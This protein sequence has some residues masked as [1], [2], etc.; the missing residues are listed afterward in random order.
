MES[1]ANI[2]VCAETPP[3]VVPAALFFVVEAPAAEPVGVPVPLLLLLPLLF[4]LVSPVGQDVTDAVAYVPLSVVV[5]HDAGRL[6]A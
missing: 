2:I 1:K 4:L 6:F 5:P 3:I